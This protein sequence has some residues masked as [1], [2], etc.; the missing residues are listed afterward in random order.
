MKVILVVVLSVFLAQFNVSSALAHNAPDI[1]RKPT[2]NRPLPELPDLSGSEVQDS[3]APDVLRSLPAPG[4]LRSSPA[5]A[6]PKG[7]EHLSDL[8]LRTRSQADRAYDIE[9][10]KKFDDEVYGDR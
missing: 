2:K 7:V 4:V 9:K 6:R 3:S 5:E 1:D 8:F 10:L